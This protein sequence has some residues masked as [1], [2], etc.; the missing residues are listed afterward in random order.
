[1]PV[2]HHAVADEIEEPPPVENAA[3]EHFQLE[4]LRRCEC[5]PLDGAPGGTSRAAWWWITSGWRSS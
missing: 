3:Q 1:V 5:L 2:E 4:Q